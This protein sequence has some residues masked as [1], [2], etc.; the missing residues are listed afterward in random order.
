MESVDVTEQGCRVWAHFGG[1]QRHIADLDKVLVIVNDDGLVLV[2]L[3]QTVNER[4][5][6]T[7]NGVCIPS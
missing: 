3:G 2:F 5:D 6:I 4:T 1:D 7:A